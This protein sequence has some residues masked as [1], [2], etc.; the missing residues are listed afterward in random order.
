MP[1][2]MN[3]MNWE[4]L[5]APARWDES[6]RPG[7]LFDVRDRS[8]GDSR[9]PFERD[10]GRIL[11]SSAFRCFRKNTFRQ[12]IAE[13]FAKRA[14]DVSDFK[15]VRQSRAH[16]IITPERKYLRFIL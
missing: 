16:V 14:S 4:R 3:P 12:T 1:N 13:R 6:R 15:A 5:I 7:T 11:Y 9:N 10:Y 8:E 2:A